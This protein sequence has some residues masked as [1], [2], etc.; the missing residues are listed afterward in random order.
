M[1]NYF[2]HF[3]HR[4]VLYFYRYKELNKACVTIPQT[5]IVPNNHADWPANTWGLRLGRVANNIRQGRERER[6]RVCVYDVCV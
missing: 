3:F 6:E 1:I 4:I 2:F 5:F